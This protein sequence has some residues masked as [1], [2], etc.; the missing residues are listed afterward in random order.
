MH[1][2][3][4]G[5]VSASIALAAPAALVGACGAASGNVI[6][7]N[8][9]GGAPPLPTPPDCTNG[10]NYTG[11]SCT[12][13]DARPCYTGPAGTEGVGTCAGG[14]Q[15][16]VGQSEGTTG[17]FGA[18][19][20]EVVPTASLNCAVV[21]AGAEGGSSP[22]PDGG[23]TCPP[24]T[25]PTSCPEV[26]VDGA[27]VCPDAGNASDS[28][29]SDAGSPGTDGGSSGPPCAQ[30]ADCPNGSACGYLISLGCAATGACVTIPPSMPCGAQVGCSATTCDGGT[31]QWAT[32]PSCSP[33]F[34]KGF[35]PAPIDGTPQQ[36]GGACAAY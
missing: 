3:R 6:V 19:Q 16:C 2:L 36:P 24:L 31:V 17:A 12:V 23:A 13:G 22:G 33:E 7:S 30:D 27:W 8:D 26:C 14:T 28:G 9:A 20:G 5:L 10:P 25:A 15:A 11:C 21:D 1:A 18:C 29:G 34:P 4:F 35:A 32:Y